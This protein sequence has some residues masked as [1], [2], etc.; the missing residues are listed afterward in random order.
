MVNDKD[1]DSKL[2]QLFAKFNEATRNVD[3]KEIIEKLEQGPNTKVPK[4]RHCSKQANQCTGDVEV[5]EVY[6]S[7]RI[8]QMSRRL[9]MKAGWSLDLTC[10]DETD[11]EL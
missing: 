2:K 1:K 6:S 4:S 9:G 10:T 7:R 3:V 11:N 8:A 5:A